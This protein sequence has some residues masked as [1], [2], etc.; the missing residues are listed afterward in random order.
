MRAGD[1]DFLYGNRHRTG[2][3]FHAVFLDDRNEMVPCRSIGAKPCFPGENAVIVDQGR[4]A[5]VWVVSR[6]WWKFSGGVLRAWGFGPDQA[7][8][9]RLIGE[10]V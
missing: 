9:S 3:R 6:I 1:L 7:A 4:E 2:D 5:P 10:M 8:R